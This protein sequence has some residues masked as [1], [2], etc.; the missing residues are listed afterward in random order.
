MR[1][2]LLE[3][4]GGGGGAGRLGR[5]GAAPAAAREVPGGSGGT[6]AL[7]PSAGCEELLFALAAPL[8]GGAEGLGDAARTPESCPGLP[9]GNQIAHVTHRDCVLAPQ[10]EQRQGR[11]LHLPL[12]SGYPE[13]L[14]SFIPNN[15]YPRD[16]AR[17]KWGLGG[18]VFQWGAG[19]LLSYTTT[20]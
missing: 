3:A 20:C 11:I 7:A 8:L 19:I 9:A 18:D 1:E 6:A 17:C 16:C 14:N 15:S 2:G 5:P 10:T 4:G 13:G 12:P